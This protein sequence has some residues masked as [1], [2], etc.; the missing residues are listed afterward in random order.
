MEG[1][2]ND[3]VFRVGFQ[4][5]SSSATDFQSVVA[6]R[7]ELHVFQPE[8]SRLPRWKPAEVRL[9]M[10]I[11]AASSPPP[12]SRWQTRMSAGSRQKAARGPEVRT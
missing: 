6:K 12:Q 5:T 10:K 1:R 4:P 11:G 7:M 3:R 8:F 2:I 9:E